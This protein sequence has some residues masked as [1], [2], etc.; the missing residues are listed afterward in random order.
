[1][2]VG[3]SAFSIFERA[4]VPCKTDCPP[5]SH[6]SERPHYPEHADGMKGAAMPHPPKPW[7]GSRSECRIDRAPI[8]RDSHL[9]VSVVSLAS[10]QPG[11]GSRLV[12]DRLR[13]TR[14]CDHLRGSSRATVKSVWRRIQPRFAHACRYIMIPG[15]P[16]DIAET[17]AGLRR[18]DKD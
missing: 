11:F 17:F 3:L 14:I 10:H 8:T 7:L 15:A 16:I 9:C 12:V 18:C 2:R 1:M 5:A 4:E 13:S 6:R